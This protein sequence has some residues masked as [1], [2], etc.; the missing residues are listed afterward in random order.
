M[1]TVSLDIRDIL[2]ILPH[3]QPF[4]LVDKVLEMTPFSDGPRTG[5]KIKAI[6]NVTFNEPF[7]AG[8]FPHRPV[9]PGVLILE[10]MAQVGGLVAYRPND[11]EMDVAI[12]RISEM[13]IRRPVVPGDQLV[14]FG[15]C[16]K[17]RG[18]MLVLQLKAFVD[19]ALVTEIEILASVTPQHAHRKS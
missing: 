16:I 11:P 8:H 6:K 12:A 1:S 19:D 7:F 18:Q 17:D 4:L 13:K 3:R 15:E 14:I 2:R 10:A 9:M 5:R